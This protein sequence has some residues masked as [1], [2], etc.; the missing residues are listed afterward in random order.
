MGGVTYGVA[1][2]VSLVPVRVLNCSGSG[3][4]SQVIA[5]VDWVTGNHPAGAPAVA[6]MSLS[7]S[8]S[9]AM[10]KAVRSSI[11]DGVTYAIAAGNGNALGIA[12]DACKYSPS[13]VTEAITVSATTSSDAKASFAN[14]GKWWDWFAPG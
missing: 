7:S 9:R 4:T 10:D 5:G 11:A 12:Q 3:S 6:N 8:A 14:Y 2:Q 1:K 13:R